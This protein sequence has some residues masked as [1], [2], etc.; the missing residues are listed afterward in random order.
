MADTNPEQL[1]PAADAAK[2]DGDK[3]RNAAEAAAGGSG[4]AARSDGR[5]ETDAGNEQADESGR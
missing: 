2:R 3:L 4:D 1:E 5:V